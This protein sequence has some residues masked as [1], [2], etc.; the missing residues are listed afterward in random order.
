M[1]RT[2][3]SSVTIEFSDFTN[4][5]CEKISK[6]DLDVVVPAKRARTPDSCEKVDEVDLCPP[7]VVQKV[8]E[9][10][11]KI[12]KD[13]PKKNKKLDEKKGVSKIFYSK[14]NQR[15]IALGTLSSSIY[16][17]DKNLRQQNE[18]RPKECRE[19]EKEVGILSMS[20]CEKHNRIGAILTSG[21]LVFW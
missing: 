19:M 13:M 1:E 20:Y 2:S 18:V 14:G 7:T 3:I 8:G 9:E 11:P 6:E 5:L 12:S 15:I 17:Y 21:M 10:L 4:Y 16:L